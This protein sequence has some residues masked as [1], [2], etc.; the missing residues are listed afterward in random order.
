MRLLRGQTGQTGQTGR[1]GSHSS[2]DGGVF[3]ANP[4][5][6]QRMATNAPTVVAWECGPVR[7][8]SCSC[9]DTTLIPRRA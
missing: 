9:A 7:V 4:T 6:W 1:T 8:E 2:P 3:L 5:A